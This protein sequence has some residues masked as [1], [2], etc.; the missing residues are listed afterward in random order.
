M[1]HWK[2]KLLLCTAAP[3][4]GCCSTQIQP[5]NN[6]RLSS[7]VQHKIFCA[8]LK[9]LWRFIVSS[10]FSS[11]SIHTIQL[12]LSQQGRCSGPAAGRYSRQLQ[13]IVYFW[14]PAPTYFLLQ[15]VSQITAT[16]GGC[17]KCMQSLSSCKG[18]FQMWVKCRCKQTVTKTPV[19]G[20]KWDF[21]LACGVNPACELI[22]RIICGSTDN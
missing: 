7:T 19:M 15:V 11:A 3:S 17:F 14:C 1:C 4:F 20:N 8:P 16:C 6:P 10:L 21:G 18:R 9:M 22:F 5:W 13:N 2:C 12:L